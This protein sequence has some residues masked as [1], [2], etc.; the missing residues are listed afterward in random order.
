M[1]VDFI[2][3]LLMILMAAGLAVTLLKAAEW[4]G[5]KR[6][7]LSKTST[8]ESGMDPIGTARERYSVKFYLVAMIF[9]VFDIEVVF[10]YPWAVSFREFVSTG[11]GLGVTAF[12]AFFILILV[13]GL[14]Y[15]IK[16]GG[17]E[18]YN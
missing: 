9:I 11:I 7:N 8:Y 4:I 1:L 16:K 14:I 2:P 18:F 12:V 15:D 10:L 5:P 13:V 3:L 6:P 17:L